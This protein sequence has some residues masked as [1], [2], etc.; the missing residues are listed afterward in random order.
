M[1]Y[2]DRYV[3]VELEDDEFARILKEIGEPNYEPTEIEDVRQSSVAF[4]QS[5]LLKDVIQ[6]YCQ[7]VNEAAKWHFELD[8]LE[9]I[10]ITK[11]A[12]GDRYDWH[13]DESEWCRNKRKEARIRKV[14]FVLLLNEDFEGGEFLLINQEIPLKAGTMIFFHSDDHHQVNAITKGERR[15]LVGWIQGPPWK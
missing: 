5:Q 12:E 9:P 15:S 1:N 6:S 3:T 7:R 2:R 13:Q 8:F 4:I 10:Q 11:Y 14:S